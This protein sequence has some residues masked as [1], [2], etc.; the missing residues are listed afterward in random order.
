MSRKILYVE[1]KPFESVSIEK[2]FKEIAANLSEDFVPEFQQAEYGNRLSDT[3][4][5]LLLFRRRPADIYHITGQIHYLAL[6]FPSRN[7]VLSIMDVRFLY[8]PRGL[9]WW[10]LKKLYLDWPVRRLRYITA[11]SEETKREIIKYTACDP[12]KITVLDLPLPVVADE[13]P[14]ANFN[15]ERPLILQVGTMENKNIPNL[16]QA[17]KG[18]TCRL[19]VIGKMSDEQRRAL[20]GNGVEFTN[21]FDLTEEEI[22][23]EYR[24]ADLVAF[25]STY[26]GFGLPIIEAQSMRKPVVTSN[27]SPMKET[28]GGAACLVDPHDPESIRRGIAKVVDD[29]VYRESLIT[30][31]LE[32]IKRFSPSAVGR[33]YDEYYKSICR[34]L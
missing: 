8:R 29:A 2:A 21:A 15:T 4:C 16:A 3:V 22:R 6:R 28:S 31:G 26:E 7:T 9:R 11:I 25:C 17:L 23:E 14:P 30:A 12:S 10:V 18:V 20:E 32:N 27:V 13:K 19:R 24:R 34:R 33:Q 5:N 1:R